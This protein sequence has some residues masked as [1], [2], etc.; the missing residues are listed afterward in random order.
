MLTQGKNIVHG[1]KLVIDMNTGEATIKMEPT[2]TSGALMTSREG[3]GNGE[4]FKAER[5]S[6]VF[7]PGQC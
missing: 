4:V 1:T 2:A 3:D 7:Y 5:P 6:A